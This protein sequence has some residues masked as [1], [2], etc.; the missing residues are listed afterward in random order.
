[1]KSAILCV[2][3]LTVLGSVA[4]GP[5]FAA[6]E[7]PQVVVLKLDDVVTDNAPRWQRVTD[8]LEDNDLKASYGIIGYSLE[9]DN[10]AYFKWIKDLHAGGRIEFWNHGYRKRLASDKAGEFEGFYEEQKKSLE[11]T[12]TLAREK[13]GIELKTFGPHWS[14]TNEATAKALKEI[15]EITMWFYGSS[16]NSGKFLFKRVLTL[17]N[18]THVP[19]F[20][21]FKT[22]YEQVARN[23]K[24]LALQ[25]HPN[26]W[27]DERWDNFVK[28][29]EYLK[30]Q[31]CVFMMPSEYVAS[32]KAGG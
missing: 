18:P 14:G 11:R 6:E 32:Q 29:I 24:C 7:T 26:S 19:N 25:G 21:K 22:R 10:P 4:G 9:D 12:Q 3:L 31:G 8:F 1:M 27:N 2:S 30:A 16:Q 5:S 15:P 20:E 13:L 28:I 23:E 17:E